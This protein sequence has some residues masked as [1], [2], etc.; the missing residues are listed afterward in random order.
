MPGVA[1]DSMRHHAALEPIRKPLVVLAE[2]LFAASK[3]R[4][5][6]VC[7]K[8]K[9]PSPQRSWPHKA[10]RFLGKCGDALRCT[11]LRE[12]ARALLARLPLARLVQRARRS[13]QRGK[14]FSDRL[15]T[16]LGP[17]AL[18]AV[19]LAAAQALAA[20]VP[21]LRDV[22]FARPAAWLASIHFG[23][24]CTTLRDGFLLAQPGREPLLV[25]TACSGYD[26]FS[27]LV[28]MVVLSLAARPGR[29]NFTLWLGSLAATYVVSIIANASRVVAAAHVDLFAA[30]LVPPSLLHGI[31]RAAGM[32]VFLPIMM[33]VYLLTE[34]REF[35][36]LYRPGH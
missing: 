15:L 17:C 34:R 33:F 26:F 10:P 21:S 16:W 30:A 23:A 7:L 29:A 11:A 4:T 28:A 25:T 35:H 36:E 9:R 14:G 13:H 3:T 27:L 1:N 6:E 2:A 24:T 19:A 12:R 18:A 22:W 5:R 8:D 20:G 32:A 31:H